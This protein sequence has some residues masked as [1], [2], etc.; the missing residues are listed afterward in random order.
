MATW[1]ASRRTMRR[2]DLAAGVALAIA[3]GGCSLAPALKVPDV[4]TTAAYKEEA[5][6][7]PAKPADRL[8]RDAWWTLYGDA[9]LDALQARLLE[10][11]PDLAAAL[12]RYQQARAFT[13]QLR[14]GLYPTLAGSA[15]MQ[16]TRQSESRPLRV[17]GP[18][19][20]NDYDSRTLGLQ[21]DYE[22]DLWGRIRNQIASGSAAE[23]AAQADLESARLSL[24]AQL[25]DNYFAL[26]GLDQEVALFNETVT[27]YGK[28]LDLTKSRHDGGLASGLDV[29]R[30][31]TQ[32]DTAR[33]QAAQQVAQR[34][35][36]EH[37]I[38]A[39]VG[40][41]PSQFTLEP[42]LA[43]IELPAIPVG[44]PSELLQR[45]PDIAAAQRRIMA[46]NANIGVARAAYFPAI[47]LS[48][49]AGYQDSGSGSFFTAPN[50]F[51]SI[52]PSLVLA[53]FDAGKRGAQVAQAQAVLEE[54]GARYRSVVLGA[55]QQVEDNLALLHHYRAAAEAER[56]AVAAAQS[57]LDFATSRYRD[58][59]ASYL[60]VVTS[61][62]AALQ[63]QRDAL[64]LDTRQRRASVQLIRALGGGWED[65]R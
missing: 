4:P 6:W 44:V 12:A 65:T 31:Q 16:R 24:Q 53:L 10:N 14:S 15:N 34:A 21:A 26:R 3:L 35:V 38:A 18:T 52:G 29:S 64:D 2:S 11:S 58:G 32:L 49:A 39:L 30:A 51:W 42:R 9:Q 61:Q 54:S 57:S 13:D 55:F 45:R 47:T 22:F 33:A 46:A 20:P 25:A 7:T 59:A 43:A 48:A 40:A 17:L 56:S 36:L 8:P 5:P 19:S 41:S 1:C 60:E 27:A 63:T 23:Q 37:A 50:L 62:A 28:A